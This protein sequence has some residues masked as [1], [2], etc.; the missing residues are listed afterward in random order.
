MKK[1]LWFVVLASAAGC[2]KTP[3]PALGV[4]ITSRAELI[5]GKRA[6]GEVGDYKV[7]NGI[8]QAIVQDVGFS[9]GFG[10]CLNTAVI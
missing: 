2:N 8:I 5:G 7:S 9:R 10:K 6:L 3:P 1:I 4:K